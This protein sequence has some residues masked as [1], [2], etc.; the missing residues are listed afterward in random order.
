M[1]QIPTIREQEY[2]P[3]DDDYYQRCFTS[4]SLSENSAF[5]CENPKHND[6][7]NRA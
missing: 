5:L 4:A 2:D 7:I 3:Q 6:L 1:L